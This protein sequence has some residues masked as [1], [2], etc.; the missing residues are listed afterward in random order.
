VAA[1]A[2]PLVVSV[3]TIV[4]L[5]FATTVVP[6]WHSTIFPPYFVAGALFSGLAMVLT[7]AI[8]LRAVYGLEGFIT[9]RHLE[10]LAKLMLAAG[11]VVG[12]SYLMEAFIAWYSGNAAEEYAL[13]NRLSGPYAPWFWLLLVANVGLPQLLWLKRVRTHTLALFALSV[14]INVGMWLERFII[15]VASLS[16]DYLPSAWG[17]YAPTLW[18][19]ATFAGSLGLFLLLMFLFVR[20][21]PVISIF[22]MREL[23]AEG[24]RREP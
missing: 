11:L 2:T 1:L 10:N 9:R 12:Y 16:R 19:W 3:H 13:L 4:S 24:E 7:I 8:P 5:D 22:E 6:G 15:V 14:V 17:Y 21:L 20:Y 18:D 23:V